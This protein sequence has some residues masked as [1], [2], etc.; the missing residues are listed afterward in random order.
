[1]ATKRGNGHRGEDETLKAM[2]DVQ[3]GDGLR[4]KA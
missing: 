4:P 2:L 1:M 3:R